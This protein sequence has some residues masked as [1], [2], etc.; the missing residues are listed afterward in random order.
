MKAG[1]HNPIEAKPK[2]KKAKSPWNFEAPAYDDRV[3]VCAGTHF[4]VGHKNPVGHE[5]DPKQFV[6]TLPQKAKSMSLDYHNE[7]MEMD[8]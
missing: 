5:G 6:S 1:F 4:G 7:S 8:R 2:E 3:K